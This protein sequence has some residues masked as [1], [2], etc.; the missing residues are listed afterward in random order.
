[1]PHASVG[2]FLSTALIFATQSHHYEY[3]NHFL[4][5]H[6]LRPWYE[7]MFQ[8]EWLSCISRQSISASVKYKQNFSSAPDTGNEALSNWSPIARRISRQAV[9][10]AANRATHERQSHPVAFA[11]SVTRTECWLLPVFD[12]KCHSTETQDQVL[13]PEKSVGPIPSW[14]KETKNSKSEIKIRLNT[15]QTFISGQP[16]GSC[17][18]HESMYAYVHMQRSLCCHCFTMRCY[19][20]YYSLYA[21]NFADKCW[22][23][24]K[25]CHKCWPAPLIGAPPRPIGTPLRPIGAP[26][27]PIGAPPRPIG[28]PLRPI[29]APLRPIGRLCGHIGVPRGGKRGAPMKAVEALP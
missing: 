8:R 28:A 20:S 12:D 7:Q 21:T 13:Q 1:M 19:V 15:Q 26:L 29:G 10:T 6:F 5:W 23:L 2:H 9:V 25:C 27:S 11:E 14:R 4:I 18:Q 17:T 3:H 24:N 22:H 16:L